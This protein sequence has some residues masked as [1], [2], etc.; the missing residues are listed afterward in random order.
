[1][2]GLGRDAARKK[3]GAGVSNWDVRGKVRR[4]RPS[5]RKTPIK[6]G[7]KQKNSQAGKCANWDAIFAESGGRAHVGE[8]ENEFRLRH[9][10]VH[11]HAHFLKAVCAGFILE[12]RAGED[13]RIAFPEGRKFAEE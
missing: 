4:K 11:H 1:M 2:A 5:C 10:A 13:D 8:G 9:G 7:L 6:Q 3:G 12:K